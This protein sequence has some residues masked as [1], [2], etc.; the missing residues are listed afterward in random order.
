MDLVLLVIIIVAMVFVYKL[1]TMPMNLGRAPR[2]AKQMFDDMDELFA[3]PVPSTYPVA[4][5]DITPGEL[6]GQ[7]DK[8]TTPSPEVARELRESER[9]L[10]RARAALARCRG[11]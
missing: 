6:V 9:Q 10:H 7:N 2:L 8:A 5:R 4:M 1:F 3:A 11:Q